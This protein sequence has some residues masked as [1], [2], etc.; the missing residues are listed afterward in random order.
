MHKL[1][2]V[3]FTAL[4][5][6]S[7]HIYIIHFLQ[8]ITWIGPLRFSSRKQDKVGTFELA[9]A[10]GT[11]SSCN[12]TFVGKTE[13]EE[14]LGKSKSFSHDN[15]LKSAVVVWEVLKGGKL[16]GLLALDRVRILLL[17]L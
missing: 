3:N 16:P 9:E 15:F 13:V 4:I 7:S 14:S 8:K 11:L 10:L 2:P 5:C 12:V 6:Y 17:Q 1:Y